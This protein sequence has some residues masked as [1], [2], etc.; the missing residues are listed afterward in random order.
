[1]I[2][3]GMARRTR[4]RVL[5]V[6]FAMMAVAPGAAA[7]APNATAEPASSITGSWEVDDRTVQLRVHSASMDTDIMVNVQR[8]ADRSVPRPTLYLLNG[9]G[10]GQDS[11]TWQKNTD[12]LR[13]LAD[14]DVNV[15]QPIGGRWSYYTDWRARDPK[16][17]VY[18]WKTF[19]TEE[20]PPLIDAEFGTTGVNAIAGL[21]TSGTS[22][23]QLPI[24][25]P[26]LYR[27]VAAYSGCAQISD[28]I[29]QQFVKMAVESW[30]GG[31][32]DNMYGPPGDPMWAANDPYVNAEGLRGLKLFISTGTGIPGMF[33]VYNGTH[34]QP[35]PRGFAN[36]L[37]LGGLIEAAVNWC[38]HNLRDRL[39]QL[40]IPATFDF[41]PT[42]THS[43][44]YWQQ[45]MKDSWPV[46]AD[47]LGLP[48]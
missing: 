7:V 47:G 20:L 29:G 30:G 36:Q 28:P 44:G 22:V 27:A 10:G 6:A 13:F 26:G 41:Q 32:T 43:W 3:S 34:M 11:A 31:D 5:A 37:V 12:V 25:K 15:V 48:R 40:G 35:G 4:G 17:G 19:L 9:G 42:G 46:L 21:S 18:K 1:M 8:P 23:L 16:L 2:G 38:T 45:A 24:A 39:H 14:K 33:D